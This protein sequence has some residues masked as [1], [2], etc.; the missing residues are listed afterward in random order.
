MVGKFLSGDETSGEKEAIVVIELFDR[1]S[2]Y[3]ATESGRD[4]F[5]GRKH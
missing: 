4:L 3:L 2:P 5:Q 1:F